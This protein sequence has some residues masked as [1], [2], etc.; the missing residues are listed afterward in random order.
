M[1]SSLAILLALHCS[2]AL[3]GHG[4]F[5]EEQAALSTPAS[6][7]ALP[8]PTTSSVF[9]LV[10]PQGEALTLVSQNGALLVRPASTMKLFTS[11]MAL[12]QGVRTDEYLS[13]ML[14]TSNNAMAESTLR[15]LGGAK[16]MR[17]FLRDEEGLPVEGA[18]KIVDGSG[19]SKANWVTCD[20][21]VGF[22]DHVRQ[23]AEFERYLS[24]LATP[25][26]VGTLD[27]RLLELQGRLFGKTGTLRTT[28]ALS[29]VVLSEK[30]TVLFCVI[31]EN[32]RATWPQERARIDA[33]VLEQIHALE[34]SR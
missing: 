26:A 25:G 1:R 23:S 24:L 16:A 12:K 3:A 18:L 34:S 10:T 17:N 2:T 11:W 20:F 5:L 30:G 13:E 32:F 7:K 19:L 14:H 21:E 33:L 31:S 6:T 27:D 15:L 9:K 28:I 22:L 8:A 29:G 4:A